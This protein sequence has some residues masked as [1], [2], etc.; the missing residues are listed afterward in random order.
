MFLPS[1]KTFLVPS[2]SNSYV[3]RSRLVWYGVLFTTCYV[4]VYIWDSILRR[5]EKKNMNLIHY[6]EEWII[7]PWKK[8]LHWDDWKIRVK[9]PYW[10]FICMDMASKYYINFV[11]NKPTLICCSHAFA[12]HVMCIITIVDWDMHKDYQPRCLFPVN[13][14]QFFLQPHPLRRVFHWWQSNLFRKLYRHKK[15]KINPL[16]IC[17]CGL[18]KRKHI[19][20]CGKVKYQME[21]NWIAQLYEL[22][23]VWWHTIEDCYFWRR[24]KE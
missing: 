13:P 20:R 5:R 12:F 14:F 18:I 17:R 7:W 16:Q 21:N 24:N 15:V 2:I 10:S 1:S 3:D 8:I 19:Y 23:H 4:V 11:M 22:M 9:K 6:E